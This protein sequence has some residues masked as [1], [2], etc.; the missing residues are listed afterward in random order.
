M[1]MENTIKKE[2][3]YD[4]TDIP[5]ISHTIV[6]DKTCMGCK[7]HKK[8]V[9]VVIVETEDGKH[10][11]DLFLTTDQTKKL[12]IGLRNALKRNEEK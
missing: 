2:P 12:I 5:T 11:K 1:E 6:H 8:D 4:M 10:S 3:E 7:R 9:L